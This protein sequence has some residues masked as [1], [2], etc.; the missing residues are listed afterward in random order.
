MAIESMHD[1]LVQAQADGRSAMLKI[2][3][4]L[5]ELHTATLVASRQ[6]RII[7]DVAVAGLQQAQAM[8]AA[9]IAQTVKKPYRRRTKKTKP[10]NRR[11]AMRALER[12]SAEGR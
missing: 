4:A 8:L 5:S 11:A 2:I 7:A 10:R 6:Q 1:R 3:N 9:A 12:R